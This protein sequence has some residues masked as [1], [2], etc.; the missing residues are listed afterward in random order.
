M[1]F[2]YFDYKNRNSQT[3]LPIVS[4]L[5]RKLVEKAGHTPQIISDF[6]GSLPPDRKNSSLEVDQC[7]AFLETV[8]KDFTRV[9]LVFDALDECSVH[10]ENPGEIRSNM[11]SAIQRLSAFASIFITSR[12][13]VK[14]T[15]E[16]STC[17]Q[18]DTQASDNDICAYLKARTANL[19]VLRTFIDQ[20]PALGDDILDIICTK[21]RG[22]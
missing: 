12:P 11:I 9:F 19:K 22:M 10:D 1:A 16:F 4:S 13:H 14:P 2:T 20:E 8:C 15:R 17:I 7:L 21:A 18:V 3:V 5:L 6:Y